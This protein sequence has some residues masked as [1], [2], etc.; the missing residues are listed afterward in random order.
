MRDKPKGG[1]V[2][3][4]FHRGLSLMETWCKRWNIEIIVDNT[5]GIYFSCS[6][7]PAESHLTLNGRNIPFVNSL[8]YLGVFFDKIF[9][10]GLHIVIIEDKAFR[11]FIR[12]Y[13]LFKSERLSTNFKL[14]L[15]RALIRNIMTFACSAWEFVAGNHLLKQSSPHHWKFSKN[16]TSRGLHMSFKLVYIIEYITKLSSQ[17]QEALQNHKNENVR[18]IGKGEPRHRKYK[19]LKLWGRQAYER[20]SF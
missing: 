3:R 2:S 20:S 19:R 15:H 12:I 11:T 8:K 14:T 9:T 7:L 17:Q 5:R 1:F 4:K 16:H 6:C 18:N 10:W 13:S